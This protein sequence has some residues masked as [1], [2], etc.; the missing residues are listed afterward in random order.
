M[1]G[2]SSF[3]MYTFMYWSLIIVQ[4]IFMINIQCILKC[5]NYFNNVTL[6]GCST[7]QNLR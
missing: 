2:L 3:N 4:L 5:C 1:N 6:Q 7:H